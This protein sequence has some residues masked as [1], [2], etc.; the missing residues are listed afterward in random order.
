MP[1]LN[2]G[3]PFTEP[4]I[5]SYNP[6]QKVIIFVYFHFFQWTEL[7]V[8]SVLLAGTGNWFFYYDGG[9]N[10]DCHMSKC[11]ENLSALPG[12]GVHESDIQPIIP[13]PRKTNRFETVKRDSDER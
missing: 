4:L 13:Q 7:A 12:K 5:I 3:G 1:E 11:S 2:D 8:S 9:W 10:P 6:Q